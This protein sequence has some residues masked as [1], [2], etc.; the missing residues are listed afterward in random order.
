MTGR[1]S[2]GHGVQPEPQQAVDADRERGQDGLRVQVR[3]HQGTGG[4]RGAAERDPGEGAESDTAGLAVEASGHQTERQRDDGAEVEHEGVLGLEVGAAD[5][6]GGEHEQDQAR[7]HGADGDP[8]TR[9]QRL[10]DDGGGE[11]RGDHQRGRD[12]DLGDVE[13]QTSAIETRCSS[14]PSR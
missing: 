4:D 6:T 3:V 11:Q 1:A 7:E 12:A 5:R 13:R 8:V 14:Q 10:A 9:C 2:Q